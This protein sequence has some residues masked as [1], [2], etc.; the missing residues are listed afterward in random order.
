MVDWPAG[1]T[2]E[3]FRLVH[4]LPDQLQAVSS[5]KGL[6]AVSGPADGFDRVLLCG[7]G[8]S[9][10]AGDLV[11]PLIQHQP[12]P[13]DV[14]RNYGLP[15]WADERTLLIA[16]SYSGN[17][18]ETLSALTEG[19]RRGCP[20]LGITS[21]GKLAEAAAGRGGPAFTV[22]ELPGGLP[23]RASLGYG[24]GALVLVLGRL[25]LVRDAEEEVAEAA[26]VLAEL[27]GP[28]LAP[29]G[30]AGKEVPVQDPAGMIPAAAL[31]A[32]LLGR[33]PVLYTV[34]DLARGVG[35]RLKGQLNEN[36]KIPACGAV[37][38]ELN[39]NDLV[40]WELAEGDRGRFVLL[41]LGEVQENERLEARVQKTRDL[42][43]VDLPV[44]HR[45]V[46]TEG[47]TLG[48]ILSLVQYGDYLSCHLA[49]LKGVDAV[50]VTRIQQLKDHLERL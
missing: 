46:P 8:G 30:A 32:E 21:G 42:L 7:M 14:H 41:V 23:P 25:G 39:H 48:R 12:L 15:H 17:T 19:R 18:E 24:L 3:M 10:I 36:S 11:Q 40:G 37:F 27:D 43:A 6:D 38:P 34:G 31:A 1:G 2:G 4:Q 44:M 9:A 49:G 26:R 22:V 28:R 33:I 29:F 50:P 35:V 5:L 20:V 47:R 45:L 16:C 13:L